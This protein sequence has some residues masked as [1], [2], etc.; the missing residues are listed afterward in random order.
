MDGVPAVGGTRGIFEIFVPGA[1]LFLNMIGVGYVWMIVQNIPLDDSVEKLAAQPVLALIVLVCFGYLLG[2]VLRLLKTRAPDRWSGYYRWFRFQVKRFCFGTLPGIVLCILG[3]LL[4]DKWNEYL[5][6]RFSK[7]RKES[8]RGNLEVFP[9]HSYVGKVTVRRLPPDAH[10]FYQKFW[11]LC[12]TP[13]YNA[14]F[15]YCKTI[16]NS[17][18]PKSAAEIYAAEALVRYVAS[19][20]YALIFSSG[21]VSLALFLTSQPKFLVFHP[22]LCAFLCVYLVAI[23][24]I[25]GN[26]RP[27][28]CKEVEIVFAA[29]LLNYY[30]GKWPKS[31]TQFMQAERENGGRS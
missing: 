17:L 24:V 15:N 13:G 23:I 26:L 20:F 11:G 27:L 4:P 30:S 8:G 28:R 3:V 25:L 5:G 12:E 29:T 6:S 9:Y 1:F 18:D 19:M 7:I 2:I 31:A 21:L 22:L 14:F 16:I 10:M